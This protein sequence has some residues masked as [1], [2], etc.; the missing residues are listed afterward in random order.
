M[1]A[2]VLMAI[3]LVSLTGCRDKTPTPLAGARAAHT[4]QAPA[5]APESLRAAEASGPKDDA[6]ACHVSAVNLKELSE[7]PIFSAELVRGQ[8]PKLLAQHFPV[9]DG[10]RPGMELFLE[11]AARFEDGGTG[12][13]FGAKAFLEGRNV[14]PALI[15]E[16]GATRDLTGE[17]PCTASRNSEE[18]LAYLEQEALLPALDEMLGELAF[19]CRLEQSDVPRLAV[20]LAGE[21]E[22]WQLGAAARMAGERGDDSL[23]DSLLP[24]LTHADTQ[25]SIPAIAALGRLGASKHVSAIVKASRAGEEGLVRAVA[26]ALKDMG[27]PEARRY[28]EEWARHHQMAAIRELAAE[29]LRD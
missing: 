9:A 12:I 19:L 28:L 29:L 27:T 17:T 16:A 8:L 4:T 10:D 2:A 22:P 11:Y 18:C 24:L 1:K 23:V 13:F 21:G 20:L 15:L 26:V 7:P 5:P 3:L 6:C 14:V 25:V